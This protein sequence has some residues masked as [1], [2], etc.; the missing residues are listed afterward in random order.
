MNFVFPQPAVVCG[1]VRN[2]VIKPG[3]ARRVDPGP[4]LV[5]ATQKTGA[6]KKPVKP[7]LTQP[8]PGETRTIYTNSPRENWE[9]KRKAKFLP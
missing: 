1:C 6:R 7:S 4:G 5:R 9:S 2:S 8:N 3:P